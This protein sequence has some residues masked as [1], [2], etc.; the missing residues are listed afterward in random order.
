[1]AKVDA[2]TQRLGHR[3]NLFN[4][5]LSDPTK[6]EYQKER[7]VSSIQGPQAVSSFMSRDSHTLEA[8]VNQLGHYISAGKE[9]GPIIWTG[10]IWILIL[11]FLI[12]PSIIAVFSIFMVVPFWIWI[13]AFLAIILYIMNFGRH[14]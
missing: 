13:I 6:S 10:F 2:E 5:I 8:K 11:F 3:A 7:L 4:K 9:A 1:M 12:G 14:D